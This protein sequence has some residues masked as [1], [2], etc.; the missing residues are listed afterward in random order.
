VTAWIN[1]V[2]RNGGKFRFSVGPMIPAPQ[3]PNKAEWRMCL[4]CGR[5]NPYVELL[6]ERRGEPNLV[7]QPGCQEALHRT[8]QI[9]EVEK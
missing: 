7:C 6:P 9:E 1:G 3:V 4:K 2:R 8:N 5:R